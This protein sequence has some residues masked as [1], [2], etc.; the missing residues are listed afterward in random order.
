MG[1]IIRILAEQRAAR[2]Q[3]EKPE[4]GQKKESQS[5]EMKQKAIIRSCIFMHVDEHVAK[6]GH[7]IP[8]KVHLQMYMQA[9]DAYHAKNDDHESGMRRVKEHLEVH[10]KVKDRTNYQ[11]V[12]DIVNAKVARH[13]KQMVD[14]IMK[15]FS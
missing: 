15:D 13:Q 4:M 14:M 12:V 7:K 8:R 9:E 11:P 10:S 5:T 6:L 1:R 3:A 2:E